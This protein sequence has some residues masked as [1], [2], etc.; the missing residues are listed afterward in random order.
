MS[1]VTATMK[2]PEVPTHIMG[3]LGA[4]IGTMYPYN[5]GN[6]FV[7]EFDYERVEVKANGRDLDGD[8]ENVTV[9]LL[10]L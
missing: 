9:N 10:G 6:G 2:V 7:I 5:D 3:P 1:K 8:I 4:I